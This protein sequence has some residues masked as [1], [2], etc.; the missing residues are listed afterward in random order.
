MY[1]SCLT[2]RDVPEA[3][4]MSLQPNESEKTD[5]QLQG[6]ERFRLLVESV[7]DYAIFMLDPQGY[8]L[9]WNAGAERIKGY[10][11]REMIGQHF[12]RFY[13]ADKLAA[14]LPQ[15]ELEVAA[16]EGRFEDGGWRVRKDGT[17]FWANVVIT[18]MRGPEGEL[19]GYAKVTSDLTQR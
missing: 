14:G 5:D 19:V 10:K 6:E 12:T 3:N 11:A 4:S 13:P 17:L 18:A 1:R 15:H 8:V 16:A 7:R 2:S 9:T